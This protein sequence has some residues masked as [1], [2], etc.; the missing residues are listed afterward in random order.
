MASTPIASASPAPSECSDG[1]SRAPSARPR[2]TSPFCPGPANRTGRRAPA[3]PT[4]APQPPRR[5]AQDEQLPPQASAGPNNQRAASA[6]GPLDSNPV[7][8]KLLVLGLN[9]PGRAG[10][11]Q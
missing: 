2:A 4:P 7:P 1:P 6:G 3:A 8:L 5:Q 10:L 9:C 11:E